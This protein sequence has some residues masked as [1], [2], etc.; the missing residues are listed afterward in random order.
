MTSALIGYT[1]FVGSNLKAQHNFDEFY[2]SKNIESIRGKS[3]DLLVF[4]AAPAQKWIANQQPAEDLDNIQTALDCLASI[5]AKTA[6]LISTVDVIPDVSKPYTESVDCH[7]SPNHPYGSNRLL[8]EDFFQAHFPDFLIVRLPAL[9]GQGLKKN[10][11]YDLINDNMLEV[12]NPDSRFQYY[13]LDR[14]WHDI[15]IALEHNLKLVHLF[16][17]PVQTREIL[18]RCF[19]KKQVGEQPASVANYDLRTDYAEL[20]GSQGGW[21]ESAASV[22]DRISQFVAENRSS[23]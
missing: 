9:F 4:S 12:I 17:E 16:T 5:S 6:I 20:Y 1:G 11:I 14:L 2:N 13:H 23:S 3:F 18:N 15:N 8:I 10:V 22:L 7:A 19:P 21:I